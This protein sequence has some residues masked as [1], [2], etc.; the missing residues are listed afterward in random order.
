LE[1][2]CLLV[3]G[4]AHRLRQSQMAVDKRANERRHD[5]NDVGAIA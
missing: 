5:F 2:K 4:N 3:E 1:L